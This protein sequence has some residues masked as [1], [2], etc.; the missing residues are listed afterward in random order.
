MRGLYHVFKAYFE[1]NLIPL[2]GKSLDVYFYFFDRSN[3]SVVCLVAVFKTLTPFDKSYLM[4][5]GFRKSLVGA[6]VWKSTHYF[7]GFLPP[8]IK[9]GLTAKMMEFKGGTLFDHQMQGGTNQEGQMFKCIDKGG[10]LLWRKYFLWKRSQFDLWSLFV[11]KIFAIIIFF[12]LNFFFV[13]IVFCMLFLKKLLK[14]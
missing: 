14:K 5:F 9:R 10:I 7:H 8:L 3:V 6:G 2:R 1:L 13:Q 12:I 11:S 4:M